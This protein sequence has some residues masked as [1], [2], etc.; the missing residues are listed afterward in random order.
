MKHVISSG[1]APGAI[2]PYSQAIEAG[3]LVF[4]SGQLPIDATTGLMA[5]GAEAQARQ[6]LENIKHILASV[7]LDMEHIVKT[8][9][10]LADMSYFAPMNA[11][12]ATFFN[13]ECPARSA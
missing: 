9:V 8:T 2:G 7:G 4:V 12:Y 10:F 1:A 3:G 11:V 5:E 6:S 13:N